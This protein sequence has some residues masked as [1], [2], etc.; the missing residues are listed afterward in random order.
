MSLPSPIS[1]NQEV[2][3]L[4]WEE[5]ANQSTRRGNRLS[6]RTLSVT[7]TIFPGHVRRMETDVEH[8]G[9]C[10][11]KASGAT[12]PRQYNLISANAPGSV[13]VCSRVCSPLLESWFSPEKNQ[14]VGIHNHQP[15]TP[16]S[17]EEHQRLVHSGPAIATSPKGQNGP[18]QHQVGPRHASRV[19][20]ANRFSLKFGGLQMINTYHHAPDPV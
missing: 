16:T 19:T 13:A 11:T 5:A 4:C 9:V 17:F 1:C 8:R 20:L 2:V 6:R 10:S 7:L 3:V 12:G 14:G 15:S 18:D